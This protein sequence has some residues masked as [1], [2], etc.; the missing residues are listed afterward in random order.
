MITILQNI[1]KTCSKVLL[2]EDEKRSYLKK[3]RTPRLDGVTRKGILKKLN[4]LCKKVT[5]CHH[6]QAIN[7]TVKKVG[8]LKIIHEKY[9]KKANSEDE[10]IFRDSFV[11]AANN[12]TWLKPYIGRAQD[13]LNP[14]LIKNLFEKVNSDVCYLLIRIVN[15]LDWIRKRLG[16]SISC[17]PAL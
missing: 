1:C 11:E 16:Q 2:T 7:G 5:I 8:P 4:T 3:L 14:L 12:D 15:Y 13:D 17:G 6:C 9:K 10:Q